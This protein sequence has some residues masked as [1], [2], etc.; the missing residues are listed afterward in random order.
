MEGGRIIQCG[1]PHD[2]VKEP[3]DQYVADFVQNMNPINM[4]KAEDVMAMVR[5]ICKVSQSSQPPVRNTPDRHHGYAGASAGLIG[6][7]DNGSVIGTIGPT[8]LSPV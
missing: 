8:E 5:R 2:I 7:V 3:A 4:L 6:I 1:T